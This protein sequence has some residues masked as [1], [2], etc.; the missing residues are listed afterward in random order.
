MHKELIGGLN[1][2]LNL[3]NETGNKKDQIITLYEKD[4]K[5]LSMNGNIKF[6]VGTAVGAGAYYV[7]DKLRKK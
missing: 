3:C 5:V 7:V 6:I 1:N 2:S 4:L